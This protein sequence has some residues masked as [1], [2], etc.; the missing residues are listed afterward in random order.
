MTH[1]DHSI[2]VIIPAFNAGKTIS[3]TLKSVARQTLLPS[4][5]IIVDDNS[6]DRE[7]L[8]DE[9]NST[10]IPSSVSIRIIHLSKKANGAVARNHGLK[11]ATGK[12]IA[13]LDADDQWDTNK[14][15]ICISHA[16]NGSKREIL[17]SRVSVIHNN[18]ASGYRP[19]RGILI[20]ENVS[21]Y[22]FLSGGFIQTSS[23]FLSRQHA[24]TIKFNESFHRHQDYDFCLRAASLG[25]KFIF[26]ESTLVKYYTDGKAFSNRTENPRFSKLWSKKMRPH[27]SRNA[28]YAF[29][30]FSVT[31]RHLSSKQYYSAVA[32]F[33][34]NIILLGPMGIYKSRIKLLYVMRHFLKK[35]R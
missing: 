17:Y 5:I 12:Y 11:C 8:L 10:F 18:R 29:N 6:E 32:C 21:E 34:F 9:I 13:F 3:R 31:A 7:T 33:V 14:L 35:R 23:I 1:E 19:H 15:R 20:N 25:F 27:L 28:Y 4:E 24:L 2:S 26:I 22:L 30:A 16:N